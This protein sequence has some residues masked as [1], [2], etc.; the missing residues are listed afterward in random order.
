MGSETVRSKSDA[1]DSGLAAGAIT[2]RRFTNVWRREG[3]TWR[4]HW[5]HANPIRSVGGEEANKKIIRRL[6]D[7]LFSK[8]NFAVVD[9]VF[10][11]EFVSHDMPPGLPRG[12]EG[13]RQFYAG[14]R[15]GLP[16]VKLTVE[17]MVAEGDK[18]VVRWRAAATHQGTFLGVPPTGKPVSFSGMAT[19]RLADGKVV[20]R[21]VEVGLLGVAEQLRASPAAP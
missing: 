14:I 17:D 3:G 8:W 7:E 6:Y 9:E 18:V 10:A 16:D 19:Y 5:R 20:E 1:P 11:A 4:Q 2:R 15:A 21:W 12:P 13:V